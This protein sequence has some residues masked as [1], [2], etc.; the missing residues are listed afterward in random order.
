MNLAPRLSRPAAIL[1]LV[2]LLGTPCAALAAGFQA[3]T[4]PAAAGAP[5]LRAMVWAPC[6]DKP[7]V[8]E[9]GPYVIH[10]SRNCAVAGHALPLIVISHGQGGSA[11]G[12]HDTATALADA[13]FVVVSFNHSGD[14]FDDDGA[15]QQLR[16]F[17][18]RPRDV[19]RVISFM[20]GSWPQRSQLDPAAIGVFGFSRGGYTALALAGAVPSVKASAQRFC[21]PWWSFVVTL[22]RRLAADDAHVTTQ[23][24]PRVRAVVVVDPLDL[25]DAAGMRNVRVPVQLWASELGGDGVAPEHVQAIRS[26][27]T[28][29]PEFRIAKGAGHFAYLAPCSPS[30]RD[31]APKL[32][33]DPAGFNR[34]R[35]HQALNSAVVEFF[36]R[37]LRPVIERPLAAEGRKF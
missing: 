21:G 6:A 14:S 17:E 27:L 3:I 36:G 35:W 33:D 29:A 34:V 30:M 32:C 24:D 22:C 11:L 13:G 1:L 37:Q 9:L 25:F 18:S 20:L 28:P 16:V 7:G 15:A 8:V 19:S 5:Q 12:H 26:A 2:L 4:V 31:A 10:A 23:A